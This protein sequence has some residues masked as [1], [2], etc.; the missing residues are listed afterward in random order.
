MRARN[1]I[2][3]DQQTRCGLNP[4]KD[5]CATVH[6]APVSFS[7]FLITLRDGDDSVPVTSH[8]ITGS[9]CKFAPPSDGLVV[10]RRGAAYVPT[11]PLARSLTLVRNVPRRRSRN[12]FPD[13]ETCG[14]ILHRI[15]VRLV[16]TLLLLPSLRIK[17]KIGRSRVLTFMVFGV[18][19]SLCR[20]RVP[21]HRR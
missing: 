6:L 5:A 18:K 4:R 15:P 11:D 14:R 17:T 2:V 9:R 10:R 19:P 7:K 3:C 20:K 8:V 1:S 13:Q 16:V 12:M 21:S